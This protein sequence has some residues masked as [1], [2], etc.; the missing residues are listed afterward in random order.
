LTPGVQVAPHFT[1]TWSTHCWVQEPL[2][3]A[4]SALQIVVTH[5]L[6]PD[7]R[8]APVAH[9]LCAHVPALGLTQCVFI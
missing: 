9:W 4:V 6:Q 5:G 3:H 1:A 7:A 8:A 2:Q